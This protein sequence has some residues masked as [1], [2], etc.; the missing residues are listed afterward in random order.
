[1]RNVT[2]THNDEPNTNAVLG[3]SDVKAAFNAGVEWALGY[4]N[5]LIGDELDETLDAIQL[6]G[7]AS[8][9]SVES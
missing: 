3:D 4:L 9:I 2:I 6:A 5:L 7:Y 1:M 8:T